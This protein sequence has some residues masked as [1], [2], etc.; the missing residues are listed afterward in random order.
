MGQPTF[1][2]Q[3]SDYRQDAVAQ[4]I[5]A[6]RVV[7][8]RDEEWP[9]RG[10]NMGQNSWSCGLAMEIVRDEK[11]RPQ[12]VV[13]LRPKY[14]ASQGYMLAASSAHDPRQGCM[15][16]RASEWVTDARDLVRLQWKWA[17]GRQAV[18]RGRLLGDRK[19]QPWNYNT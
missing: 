19:K 13:V 8:F 11:K 2:S 18:S 16:L 3:K 15:M 17:V 1:I 5:E 7:I 14:S 4:R 10:S 9:E 12:V 6:A